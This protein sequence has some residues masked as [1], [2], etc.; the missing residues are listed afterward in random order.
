MNK[1]EIVWT[2]KTWNP[3]SGCH[4]VSAECRHCYARTL[5]EQ[6]RGTLAFQNGFDVVLKPHKLSEPRKLR[7]P[8][9]IFV[10]SMS[11]L[12]LDEIPD[13]Y[14]DQILEVIRSTPRHIFQTLT[15]RPENAARYFSTRKVP[16]N[17]WLGVTCGG[18]PWVDRIATLRTIEA[19]TRFVSVEPLI[20]PLGQVD[21]TGIHWVIVG[22]ESGNHL[23]DPTVAEKRALVHR[24]NGK[25]Q[26]REDRMPWVRE[27]RDQCA[28]T[29]VAL[30]FKQWG[31]TKGHLAGRELDGRIHDEYPTPSRRHPF[32]SNA[33]AA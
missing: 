17:L 26:A 3:V 28:A 11:D 9:L 12:F 14:R 5:A 6:K 31:G 30:L 19:A 16:V 22:G 8:T 21:L 2:E 29:G 18:A 32:P 13:D 33:I 1:T 27:I 4:P 15:K 10:N 20:R 25:W 24:P 23:T 7:Q